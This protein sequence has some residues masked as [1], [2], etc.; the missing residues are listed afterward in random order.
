MTRFGHRLLFSVLATATATVDAHGQPPQD[1]VETA[2]AAGSFT[3]LLGAAKAAGL[4]DALRG[5]GPFTV[6]AP[7][8]DAFAELPRDTLRTLLLPA[9]RESLKAIIGHHVVAGRYTAA[10]AVSL[11]SADSLAGD[12]LSIRLEAGRLLVGDARVVRND[13]A[14]SN[15]VIH[16]IDR[17]LLPP[18]PLVVGRPLLPAAL[19]ELAIERGVPLYN[20][21]QVAG[22]CAVYEIAAESLL[23]RTE[24]IAAATRA[25]VVDALRVAAAQEPR[26]AA[27]TLRRAL[28]AAL[29]AANRGELQPG[30]SAGAPFSIEFDGDAASAFRPIND[31]VMGGRSASSMQAS[32]DGTAIFAGDLS[33]ENNGGFASVRTVVEPG[34]LATADGLTL[35]VRGDGRSYRLTATRSTQVS[36]DVY[37]AEFATTAGEWVEIRVPFADF[38]RNV[39]GQTIAS[40]PLDGSQIRTL[41][42]L[43]G[44]KKAGSFRLEIDWLR[45]WRANDNRG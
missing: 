35:R 27:W 15:G 1:L 32:G 41:G 22:C 28:D 40:K 9:N 24:E 18:A 21:G 4:L 5:E 23:A 30:D 34:A 43:L 39:M 7:T 8:D 13:I 2:T 16:V 19:I 11:G 14:A 20:D 26:E 25:I 12:S 10:Q 38:E 29:A 33:L 42:I 17:V 37:Q 31:T 36:P 45:A 6:F 3:T 44:D